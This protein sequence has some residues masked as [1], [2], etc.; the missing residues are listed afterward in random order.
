MGGLYEFLNLRRSRFFRKRAKEILKV[1]SVPPQ[2]LDSTA[3]TALPAPVARY[4]RRSVPV[5]LPIL[6]T[7]RL[8]H[9]G[10]FRAD[11]NKPWEPICGEQ[12]ISGFEAAFVWKGKTKYFTA[13]DSFASNKGNLSVWL[14]SAFRVMNRQ[15]IGIDEG[16]LLRWLCESTVMPSNFYPSQTLHWEYLNE[17]AAKLIY[18]HQGHKLCLSFRF[19]DHNEITSVEC[20]RPYDGT[21]AQLWRG[22]FTDYRRVQGWHVPFELK[23]FWIING[24]EKA[25]AKFYI[26]EIDFNCAELF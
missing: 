12:Y 25:Y 11:M 9:E 16:E 15:G 22:T 24:S 5:H 8:R 3:L 26:R 17:R 2:E 18:H 4:L 6:R 10:Y 7:V 14:L 13:I 20:M 23:A 1:I 19:N 21:D